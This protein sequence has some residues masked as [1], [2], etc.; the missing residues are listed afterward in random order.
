MKKR[1]KN[2]QAEIEYTNKPGFFDVVFVNDDL[3]LTYVKLKE[4]IWANVL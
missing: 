2:A 3:D 1:L 4:W